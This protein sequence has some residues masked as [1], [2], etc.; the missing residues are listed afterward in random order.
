MD[1]TPS[2]KHISGLNINP[3]NPAALASHIFGHIEQIENKAHTTGSQS[4]Q[5]AKSTITS[6]WHCTRQLQQLLQQ[7]DVAHRAETVAHLAS[8]DEKLTTLAADNA[9][10][11][12][13]VAA[14]AAP[15]YAAAAAAPRG[16]TQSQTSPQKRPYA[17]TRDRAV[18]I[19]LRAPKDKSPTALS[20]LTPA[21]M[22]DFINESF[23][24]TPALEQVKVRTAHRFVRSGD[25][26]LTFNARD[27]AMQVAALEP[28]LWLNPIDP[29]LRYV[30][31]SFPVV[32]HGVPTSLGD[33]K[34]PEWTR[35][36]PNLHPSGFSWLR[37]FDDD[38]RPPF[39]SARI[40][41]EDPNEANEAIARGLAF[42]GRLTAVHKARQPPRK[43]TRCL[44]WGHTAPNCSHP[45][46]C[47]HCGESSHPTD[48]HNDAC[49]NYDEAHSCFADR[50]HC[51]DPTPRK[52]VACG[53][54]SH[55]TFDK[56]CPETIKAEQAAKL[57][58][59]ATGPFYD[60]KSA[61]PHVQF[62]DDD[63]G[64]VH[65]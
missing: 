16:P 47:L 14:L 11:R 45:P 1:L 57:A 58:Y 61:P 31:P 22:V 35:S 15:S 4:V 24:K 6:L 51:K 60:V 39:A 44:R 20:A 59:L 19:T 34:E 17:I 62:E 55:A 43:C 8:I 64:T 63:A 50:D 38:N 25:I 28:A 48:G 12:D 23:S 32:A 27:D 5:I 9:S 13:Q 33:I 18:E 2:R 56:A 52:C 3:E 40:N 42:G 36:N 7:T 21:Q 26:C 29:K 41:F 30:P 54:A 65:G 53:D 46:R 37:P 49:G 10:L